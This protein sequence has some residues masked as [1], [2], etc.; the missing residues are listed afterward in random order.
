MLQIQFINGMEICEF[1]TLK[2]PN[3]QTT[4]WN[5]LQMRTANVQWKE[6]FWIEK[7]I[8]WNEMLLNKIDREYWCMRI[9]Y[10]NI[11]V[12]SS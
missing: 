4:Q 6:N 12:Q 5:T 7:P 9:P 11:T 2:P 1:G 3:E 8:K 10:E